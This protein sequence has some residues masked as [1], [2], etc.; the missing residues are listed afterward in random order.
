MSEWNKRNSMGTAIETL[1]SAF[2]A[3]AKLDYA[4]A[5]LADLKKDKQAI[6]KAIQVAEK[7][8]EEAETNICPLSFND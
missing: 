8:L 6:D 3:E 7:K 1:R 5:R 4:R 2:L